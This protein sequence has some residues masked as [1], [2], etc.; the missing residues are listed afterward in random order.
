[1]AAGT[2]PPARNALVAALLDQQVAAMLDFGEK[3]LA[4]FL[5]EFKAADELRG[6]QVQL[7]GAH[8]GFDTGTACGI[9]ADG[10]LQVEHDGRIHRIIAGEVSVRGATT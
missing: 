1:L 6:R 3:G 10:A 7:Q 5:A 8:A 4:P 9:A 2:G